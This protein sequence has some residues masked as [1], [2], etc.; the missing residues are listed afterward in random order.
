MTRSDVPC[1]LCNSPDRVPLFVSRLYSDE[2]PVVRCRACGL[3]FQ[4]PRPSDADLL[5]MYDEKY[6]TGNG[7]KPGDYTY[8]DERRHEP[9]VR[10]KTA[11]RL[12]RV[13]TLVRPGRV[14]DAG[15]SFG[16][17]LAEARH[18]G[19]DPYGVDASPVAAR[20]VREVRRFPVHEGTF[21]SAPLAPKSVRLVHMS[22]F[23]E[24]CPS[25]RAVVKKAAG[26]LEPGGLLVIGTANADSLARRLRGARWGYFMPGHVVFFS[27]R[28]L[29]RL[30]EEEGF[31]VHRVFLGD[32]HGRLWDPEL[33]RAHGAIPPGRCLRSLSLPLVGAVG[34]GMVVYGVRKGG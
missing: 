28:L 17:F 26:V 27:A 3:L 9:E 33:A 21:E 25:P 16:G 30:L 11:A 15:C 13:E 14:V 20:H 29:R 24:H 31:A 22:E 1:P 18:R 34:A 7:A 6:F 19:W 8:A 4:S 10:L 12:A 32:D 23:L 5:G 2:V